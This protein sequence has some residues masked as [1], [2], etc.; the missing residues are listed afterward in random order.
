MKRINK[1]TTLLLALMTVLM[2]SQAAFAET[3]DG[4][5]FSY[6]GS[7]ISNSKANASIDQAISNLEPGDSITFTF[8]YK[9]NSDVS[10]EWYLENQV[11][12]TLEESSKDAKDGGYTYELIN[13]GKKEGRVVIFSSKA[14][15]G[16]AE[17]NPDKSD[18]GLKSAT[19]ATGDWLY[20]DTLAAGQSGT[21]TLTVALDGESQ[22]NNYQTTNGQLRIAYGVEDTAVGED[23]IKHRKG[24][25]TGDTTNLILP[26][27][28][29]IG[30]AILLILA[31]LSYRKDRKDGE[32]A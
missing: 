10:T 8:T 29:F 30:A 13:N 24:V 18:Q 9:N 26:A 4:G 1:I 6:N 23:I 31:I 16:K 32:E 2:M 20:I 19:N 14:V 21:T 3:Y 17:Q 12:K 27:A 5:T 28:A 11:I 22:A 15:A 7:S 25:D